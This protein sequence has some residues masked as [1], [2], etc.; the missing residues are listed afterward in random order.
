M[1]LLSAS[2]Y[3]MPFEERDRDVQMTLGYG[4]QKH[5]KTGEEFFHH[6]VDFNTN[7]YFLAAVADGVVSGIGVD[8]KRHGLFLV[9]KY[10]KY[11]VTYAHLSN[12]FVQFGQ[13]VKAGLA[14]GVSSDMLHMEVK[15][16]GEEI[17]PVEFI[18][19]LYGNVK[20]WSEQGKLQPEFVAIDA[21]IHTDYDADKDEIERLMMRFFTNYMSDLNAGLYSCPTRTEQ[22][23]RNV[24]SSAA[25]KDYFYETLP[26]MA[27]PLGIGHRSIPL[28]EKV[29][30]LLIGDFLNY[31][32]LR[33]QIFLSSMTSLE[34]KKLS[35]RP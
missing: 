5:P 27:N 30:N 12:V 4:K 29:Q 8:R 28:V 23:L 25:S 13:K 1:N 17:D 34:K 16:N 11:E 9:T 31:L 26:S 18:T 3:C 22:S 32:A 19:M 6:G 2:G 35:G 15:Y 33:H 14:V 10:G 7:N 21:D 20:M 24:F